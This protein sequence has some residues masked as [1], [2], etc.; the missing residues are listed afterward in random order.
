[1]K[2]KLFRLWIVASVIWAGYIVNRDWEHA[3]DFAENLYFRAERAVERAH[4]FEREL[5][6]LVY[7]VYEKDEDC[8]AVVRSLTYFPWVGLQGSSVCR[9]NFYINVEKKLRGE[10]P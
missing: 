7:R 8:Y 9:D 2:Y 4:T 10:V 1:M 3:Q 6:E 5:R